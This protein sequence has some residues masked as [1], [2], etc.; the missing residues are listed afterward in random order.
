MIVTDGNDFTV[1]TSDPANLPDITILKGDA[2]LYINM[3]SI[4]EDQKKKIVNT[5]DI[6]ISI[7]EG[8]INSLVFAASAIS[9]LSLVAF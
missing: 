8:A 1:D 3:E 9:M 2:A 5:L 7:T 4:Q 6:T